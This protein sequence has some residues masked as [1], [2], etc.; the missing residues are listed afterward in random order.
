MDSL[1]RREA[2]WLPYWENGEFVGADS[3]D[4]KVSIYNRPGHGFIAVVANMG[5][6]RREPLVK[7][8]LAKLGQ[9]ENLVGVDVLSERPVECEGGRVHLLLEPMDFAVLRFGQ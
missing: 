5:S 6:R 9:E 2:R 7:F 1:G 4:V 3:N 8:D